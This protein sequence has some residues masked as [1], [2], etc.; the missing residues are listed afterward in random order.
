MFAGACKYMINA[1]LGDNDA[2][3]TSHDESDE[4]ALKDV[5]DKHLV[6]AYR[7]AEATV[8]AMR[9]ATSMLRNEFTNRL[10]NLRADAQEY[11][12][13]WTDDQYTE[14]VRTFVSVQDEL[15]GRESSPS[16][17]SWIREHPITERQRAHVESQMRS[18][19]EAR[20][21]HT[22]G[23]LAADASP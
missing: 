7:E 2:G 19:L 23:I 6:G 5:S 11:M 9:T 16:I 14:A 10:D 8:D 3:H 4:V 12:L 17:W 1:M 13:E 22:E 20:L 15:N 21:V 18:M